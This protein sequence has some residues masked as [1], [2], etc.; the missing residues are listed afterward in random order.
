MHFRLLSQST[1]SVGWCA[2]TQTELL[3]SFKLP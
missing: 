2:A 3:M 1:D